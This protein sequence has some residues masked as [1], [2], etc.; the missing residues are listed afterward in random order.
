MV[1][2]GNFFAIDRRKWSDVCD[3]SLN[4]AVAFLVL[5]RGSGPDNRRTSWSTQAI[6][7]HAG[8]SRGRARDAIASLVDKPVIGRLRSGTRPKY[9]LGGP[10]PSSPRL[11]P[12]QAGVLGLVVGGEQPVI[13]ADRQVAY[14]LRQKGLLSL[15][16]GHFSVVR[17]EAPEQQWIWLPNEIVTGVA[18]EVPPVRLLRQAQAVDTLRLFIDCYGAQNLRE[19]GGISRS[20][21]YRGYERHRVGQQGAHV[22]WGF[23]S[24]G[25]YALRDS[26]LIKPHIED[27]S[28]DA[29]G[30]RLG[31]L[32]DLGLIEWVPHLME[33]EGADAEAIHPLS[34]CATDGAA[35]ELAVA[36]NK[37]GL[38]MLTPGQVQGARDNCVALVVPV[39]RH[40][41]S[42]QLIDIAR[43]RYR[44]KTKATAAWW[45][46]SRSQIEA[47]QRKYESLATDRVSPVFQTV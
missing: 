11:T 20:A 30:R 29:F 22:I 13:A 44:P 8:M 41:A 15:D 38:A 7:R 39:P 26:A 1:N 23:K 31:A 16:S 4:V 32:V 19:D 43:L 21:V 6:E 2:Q 27:D 33:G 3:I 12:R 25:T 5:A 40:F 42:V 18:D 9:D 10:E 36:A 47:W 14:N 35:Y 45:Q 46:N 24:D 37:A 28:I 34:F 17:P